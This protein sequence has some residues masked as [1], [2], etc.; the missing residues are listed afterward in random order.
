MKAK[1]GKK[2]FVYGY[3]KNTYLN[4]KKLMPFFLNFSFKNYVY[5]FKYQFFMFFIFINKTNITHEEKRRLKTDV[6]QETLLQSG[7]EKNGSE[8]RKNRIFV[9][10]NRQRVSETFVNKLSFTK[11]MGISLNATSFSC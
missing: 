3:A 9:R 5:I 6:K 2:Y 4:G 8:G 10:F 1:I 7:Q 11:L